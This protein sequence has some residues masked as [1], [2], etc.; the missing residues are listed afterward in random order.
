MLD[1]YG[2]YAFLLVIRCEPG[3]LILQSFL[4]LPESPFSP[5]YFQVII[6]RQDDFANTLKIC[7][8]RVGD[9]GQILVLSPSRKG[10]L[11]N[12][13]FCVLGR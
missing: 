2:G 11:A 6:C 3:L 4:I 10:G 9:F 7:E 8:E 1:E 5:G 12:K 13:A